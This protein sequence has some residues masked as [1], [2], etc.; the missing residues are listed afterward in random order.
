MGRELDARR[1]VVLP[2]QEAPRS[3]ER[4]AD[5]ALAKGMAQ[6]TVEEAQKSRR[7]AWVVAWIMIVVCAAQAAAIALLLPLKDVVPYTLLVDRQTGYLEMARGVTLGSLPEDQAVV[8]SFIA[9]YVLARETFDAADYEERYRRVALWSVD[10]A[11]DDYVRLYQ[12]GAP[13]NM[14]ADLRPDTVVTVVVKNVELIDRSGARVRFELTRRDPGLEPQ[15]SEWQAI[16]A[17]RFTGAPMRMEDRLINPL[18]FQVTS[19][20]RDMLWQPQQAPAAAL[21]PSAAAAATTPP[22]RGR[23]RGETAGAARPEA[24]APVTTVE[25]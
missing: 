25:R 11:R 2:V 8:Q 24:P 4:A 15:R 7:N 10:A 19:Y 6:A 20:R 17:F 23:M 1:V 18:G 9:Q 13:G 16:A 5:I 12:P 21:A 3:L 22:I 14:L